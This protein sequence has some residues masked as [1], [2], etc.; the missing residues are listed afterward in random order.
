[1]NFIP[2]QFNPA[3]ATV[4]HVDINSCFATIE[5]QANPLL[6]GK[7]VAVAAYVEDHGCILAASIEAKRLGIKT[8]MRVRDGKLIY[9]DLTVLAPDPNKYRSVNRALL[10]LLQ[11]YTD[12][13]S[14]ESIDEMALS[15]AHTPALSQHISKNISVH[16]AMLLIAK[17][18]KKL[19]REEIGDWITVSI[20]I[21][22]NRYLAKVA[23]GLHKP[24]GLDVLTR[25]TILPVFAHL[26][27]EDLCGIKAGNANHL[28]LTGIYSPVAFCQADAKALQKAFRSV[29][30]YHWWLRLH[31]WEDGSLYKTFGS[32]EEE[33]KSFGQS[34]ALQKPYA[35]EDPGLQQI[36][37]QL[38]MKMGRRIRQANFTAK[39]VGVSTLFNDYSHWHKQETQNVSSYAD[40][41]FYTHALRLLHQAPNRPVRI[42]AV[43]TFHLRHD[44]YEQGNLFAE[45][46]KKERLTKA[47]DSVHDR[48]GEFVIMSGRMARMEQKVLDRIAFGKVRDIYHEDRTC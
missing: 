36:L 39:G 4:M 44:L 32:D 2:E 13:V 48:W 25:E 20:G 41:D 18:I 9:P 8:G 1:M 15:L 3:P 47:I 26:K 23:S 19:V 35:P 29:N 6:R 37:A 27:L 14:V 46:Q 30:G 33:Q 40:I 43:Y 42:L 5:Q 12:N 17:D 21:A 31:G 38:V 24:D 16:D 22:P 34:Y 7:P 28:R 10:A 45:D 11:R